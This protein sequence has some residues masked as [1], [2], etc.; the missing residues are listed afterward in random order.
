[1]AKEEL[2]KQRL[3]FDGNG[4]IIGAD[5]REFNQEET[6]KFNH[7]QSP[8]GFDYKKHYSHKKPS[9]IKLKT[10]EN[11]DFLKDESTSTSVG[12]I[13]EK[14]YWNLNESGNHDV[15]IPPLKFSN[16]KTQEDVVKEIVELI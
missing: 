8:K 12:N 7:L 10:S 15:A 6:K 2:K 13:F 1:M 14:T 9:N 3:L 5:G 11:L 4:K 16:K